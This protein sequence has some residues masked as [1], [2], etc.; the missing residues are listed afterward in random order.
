MS[1]SFI[2]HLSLF[3]FYFI[4]I[5]NFFNFLIFY[6]V[7]FGFINTRLTQ[8]KNKGA[9]IEGKFTL[10]ICFT[11]FHSIRFL[12]PFSTRSFRFLFTRF[13]FY[14]LVS[15][16]IHS[17]LS[18]SLSLSIH[19]FRFLFTRFFRFRFRF[20]LASLSLSTRF[21]FAFYSL[22]FRFLLASLSLSTHSL[23]FL[24]AFA[25]LTIYLFSGRKAS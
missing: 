25:F 17:L 3:L 1:P 23:R 4:F 12:T 15:L 13:A 2:N 19:S 20:L 6:V 8:S 5:F 9:F 11:S 21:A 22:R 10:S 18:L 16:S 14:S 7:A 24:L